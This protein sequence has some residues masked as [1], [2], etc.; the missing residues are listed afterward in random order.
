MHFFCSPHKSWGDQ[1]ADASEFTC[2]RRVSGGHTVTHPRQLL[3][4]SHRLPSTQHGLRPG[5]TPA[6]LSLC[7][8][9]PCALPE[10]ASAGPGAPPLPWRRPEPQREKQPPHRGA[11][12]F[13]CSSS[14]SPC[15]WPA[16]Q[17]HPETQ[18][19]VLSFVPPGPAAVALEPTPQAAQMMSVDQAC[20]TRGPQ[21]ACLCGLC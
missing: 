4:V 14:R 12:G 13:L 20:Q 10:Q 2:A 11:G 1:A 15:Q 3:Q 16:D 7:T 17:G 8:S 9:P 5:A 6:S 19:K 18:P 21:A